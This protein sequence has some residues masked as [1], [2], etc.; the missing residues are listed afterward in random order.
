MVTSPSKSPQRPFSKATSHK[1]QPESHSCQPGSYSCQ[2]GSYSD[3]N[4]VFSK[5]GFVTPWIPSIVSETLIKSPDVT[6]WLIGRQ[7]SLMVGCPRRGSDRGA[8][9]PTVSTAPPTRGPH[10]IP[11]SSLTAAEV[12]YETLAN[13]FRPIFA[14][15]AEGASARERDHQLPFA[16][17]RKL[18]EA[19]FGAIPRTRGRRRLRR[20]PP[21]AVPSAH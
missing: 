2:P 7:P 1:C 17:I 11:M 18:T 12:D 20:I 4:L 10:Q 16:E 15:I 21:P 14:K 3:L 6:P 8:Q 5:L 9:A 13:P 19:G